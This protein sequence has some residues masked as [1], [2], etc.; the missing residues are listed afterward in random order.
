MGNELTDLPVN[1][2]KSNTNLE[3][4]NLAENEIR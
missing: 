4:L 2:I 1:L 3:L